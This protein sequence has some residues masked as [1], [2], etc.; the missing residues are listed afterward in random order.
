MKRLAY[1]QNQKGWYKALVTVL[2]FGLTIS[3]LFG[4]IQKVARAEKQLLHLQETLA[5]IRGKCIDAIRSKQTEALF[6]LIRDHKSVLLV[7]PAYHENVGTIT[8]Q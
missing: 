8:S 7:D 4:H 3:N 6:S 5:T 2:L 1:N